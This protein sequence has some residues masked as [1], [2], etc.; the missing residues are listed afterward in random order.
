MRGPVTLCCWHELPLA[1]GNTANE[2]GGSMMIVCCHCAKKAVAMYSYTKV[3]V[4]GHG[5]HGYAM[6]KVWSYPQIECEVKS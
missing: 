5:P 3:P 4:V 1:M 2:N 6:E